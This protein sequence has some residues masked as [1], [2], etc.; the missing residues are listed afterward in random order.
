MSLISYPDL[1]RPKEYEISMSLD[2]PFGTWILGA[3]HFNSERTEEAV[4]LGDLV[5][6]GMIVLNILI[7]H[8]I[9]FS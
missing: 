6:V 3:N 9:F 4:L 2:I 1:P 7:H 8:V 5:H